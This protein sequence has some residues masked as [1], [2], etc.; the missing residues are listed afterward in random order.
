[1]PATECLIVIEGLAG[2]GPTALIV[3]DLDSAVVR[4]LEHALILIVGADPHPD[5]IIAILDGKGP[6]CESNPNRPE[7]ADFLE[8]K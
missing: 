7:L 3:P 5:E 2:Q 6:V 8:L 1:M 4:L